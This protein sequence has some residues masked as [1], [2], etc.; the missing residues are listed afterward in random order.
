MNKIPRPTF[1]DTAALHAL[2]H[3]PD[4][5]SHPNLLPVLAAVQAGYVQYVAANGNA[6]L[7]T[8]VP[9][10]QAQADFLRGHYASPP[11]DLIHIKNMRAATEHLLCPM[12]GS[13]HRG[14]LD[15]ILPKQGHAAFAVFSLNLVP[16]CKCN[17]KR[18][19]QL[20]GANPGER[21]LHPYFDDCLSHRLV[22]ARFEA[23][24]AVPR[25][26]IRLLADPMHP[27]YPAIAFHFAT[28]VQ[29]TALS[30]Y[31]ADRW[32]TLYRK[33][34][35]VVRKLEEPMLTIGDLDQVLTLEMEA[36][37]DLHK[38]KNNWNSIFVAGL[39]DPPVLQWLFDRLNAPGRGPDGP[40]G[41]I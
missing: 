24:G 31:V 40:L 8:P 15:H 38:G 7:V 1:N 29:R 37:D 18:G 12:C 5:R 17:N 22:V 25:T 16:A 4:V 6:H 35:L 36:L 32:S 20:I 28:I 14:T 3:N 34:S 23:L 41:P 2:A 21:I 13:M 26:S 27:D 10:G 19:T 11:Q 39:L 9:I 33:P 30:K